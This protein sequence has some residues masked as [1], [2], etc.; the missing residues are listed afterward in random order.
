MAS[1]AGRIVRLYL[2]KIR[3]V[4]HHCRSGRTEKKR[5]KDWFRFLEAL[6]IAYDTTS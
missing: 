1:T 2:D 6:R 3:T 5:E 4:G